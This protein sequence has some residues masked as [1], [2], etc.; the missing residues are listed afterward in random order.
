MS[1]NIAVGT[2]GGGLW[3]GYNG[4]E[5]WRQIQGPIDPESN[6]RALALNPHDAQHLL[7]SVAHDGIYQSF[8]GGSRWEKTA[9]L[10][11]R[12]IWSLAF[13][14]HDPDRI[15]AGTRPGVF[16]SQDRGTSFAEL[17]TS[18]STQCAIGVPRTTNVV[19]DPNDANTVYASVEIDGLHRSRD[20]GATWESLG[21]LGPSEFY[22]DVHGFALRSHG[23]GTELLVTSPFGLGRSNDDG[24]TWNW[25]EFEAFDDS[26]FEFAYSRCIRTPWND[27]TIIVCVGDYI[28]GR[29]GAIE[30]SKDGGKSFT[31]ADLGQTPKATMYWLATH[32]NLPGVAL[33]TSVYGQIYAT[34]DYC[35]S[36]NKLDR[37]LGEVRASLIVPA[38]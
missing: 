27:E 13:D 36:W 21:Q 9:Q 23:E 20:R 38:L 4:G 2:V 12:P 14:P 31:R 30:V 11:D 17:M 6:V 37:E 24:E 32:Q 7:A 34:D 33:A 35:Q 3:V 19:V 1:Y 10:A 18:I 5:K 16:A 26:K 8:D 25:H 29:I 28:P 15:Y 22:N